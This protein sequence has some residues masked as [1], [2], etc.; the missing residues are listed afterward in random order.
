MASETDIK[1]LVHETRKSLAESSANFDVNAI[2]RG[3][4]LTIVGALRALQNP[5]IFQYEHYRQAALAVCAGIALR[6]IIAAPI[7]LLKATIW[8]L[9]F[10]INTKT[11][12]WDDKL[13]DGLEF[14]ANHV[15]QLPFFVMSLMS[16]I[17]PTLDNVFMD[18]LAWVD[19][20]YVLKHKSDDP[21]NLRAMYYPNLRM[22]STHGQSGGRK[23]VLEAALAFF[24]RFGRRAAISLGVYAC[25]FLPVVGRFVLPASSFYTFNEAV[26]P[27]PATIIFA[28]GV[29][30]PRRYLVIFLQSYFASRS[31]MRQLLQPYFAR[32]RFNSDQKKKF[33]RDREGVLFGF[34]IGF[35]TFL[36]IPLFGVLIYGVAEAST[37]YLITKI[38]DP[39]PPPTAGAQY[40][41]SQVQWRNK[42]EFLR[43]PLDSLDSYNVAGADRNSDS[44]LVEQQQPL[45]GKKYS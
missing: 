40:V 26:G 30:L 14:I 21:T 41:Q 18:S 13:V 12:T 11:A 4:Q 43:L 33:F 17:T 36:K 27:V 1:G 15:L 34:A 23:P 45:E 10:L 9:S 42:H 19:R 3:A 29:L 8:C 6:L 2:L 5:G 44:R 31:L 24:L 25:S 20:T 16:H 28:I 7:L 39:P 32:I 22:Y 35:Y 38:T 37:A